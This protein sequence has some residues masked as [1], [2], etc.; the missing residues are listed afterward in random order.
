[1]RVLPIYI[2]ALTRLECSSSVSTFL[3]HIDLNM[4]QYSKTNSANQNAN[5]R[6][7]RPG[8]DQQATGQHGFHANISAISNEREDINST[9]TDRGKRAL[10]RSALQ[11]Q[12]FNVATTASARL[13]A[14]A[15][16]HNENLQSRNE[17]LANAARDQ[18]ADDRRVIQERVA[19][20]N[21]RTHDEIEAASIILEMA[22]RA[23]AGEAELAQRRGWRRA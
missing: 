21:G 11:A 19:R 7:T 14:E 20:N 15:A 13:P 9:L 1:M 17:V 16:G 8:A 22:Q 3:D 18:I 2:S 6:P 5:G 12:S 10:A 23:E 4:S